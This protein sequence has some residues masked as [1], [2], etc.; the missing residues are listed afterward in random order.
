[1]ASL[2]EKLEALAV[3]MPNDDLKFEV[4]M[5]AET[6]SELET[7]AR[8]ARIWQ[9]KVRGLEDLCWGIARGKVQLP[10]VLFGELQPYD[11]DVDLHK[12]RLDET[13]ASCTHELRSHELFDSSTQK[14]VRVKNCPRCC[15]V[16][17]AEPVT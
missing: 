7:E 4:E 5:L 15:Y 11:E 13:I 17:A 2:Y 12:L 9:G 3:Q 14:R 6:A 8:Y 16:L 10:K 1:M